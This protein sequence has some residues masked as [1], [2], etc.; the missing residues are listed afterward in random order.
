MASPAKLFSCVEAEE[1]C[2]SPL[3]L[4]PAKHQYSFS[5]SDRF[6]AAKP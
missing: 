4:S 3:N 1:I 2:Q 6:K 5:K